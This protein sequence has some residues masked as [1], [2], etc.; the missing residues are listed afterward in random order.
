MHGGI[1]A[2][3][4][5]PGIRRKNNSVSVVVGV[6]DV[7]LG[8]V[9][10]SVA[11]VVIASPTIVVGVGVIGGVVASVLFVVVSGEASVAVV[12]GLAGVVVVGRRVVV[13]RV[14][15][16]LVFVGTS[17]SPLLVRTPDINANNPTIPSLVCNSMVGR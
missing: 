2:I 7:V 8:V 17:P 1:A 6:V 13:G 4:T 16:R 15:G 9:G 5:I 12:T 10:G 11:A 14:V 3:E